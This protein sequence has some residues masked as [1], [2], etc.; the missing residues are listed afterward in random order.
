FSMTGGPGAG[1]FLSP[2]IALTDT[3][4]NATATFTAGTLVSI[5]EGIRIDANISGTTISTGRAPSGNDL[6]LTIGGGALSVDFGRA[7]VLASSS[8]E[9]LYT[10][11]Y[12][13]IVADAAGNPV[14]GAVVTLRLQ[15]FAFSNGGF[16][17]YT[18]TYCSEDRNGN[19]SLDEGEDGVRTK[20]SDTAFSP[21]ICPSTMPPPTAVGTRDAIL[22]P[23]NSAGGTVPSVLTTD[24]TGVAPFTL[25]YLKSSAIFIVNRLTATVSSNGTESSKSLIFRLQATVPDTT[26]CTLPASPYVF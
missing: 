16:C 19:N 5:T 2:A 24:A 7:S 4:G 25:T 12:S 13:V 23:Q 17:S 10:Q 21:A 9:T 18:A 14:S 8:D 15:P 6:L 11:A 22:T 1:E 20:I 26:P 3:S